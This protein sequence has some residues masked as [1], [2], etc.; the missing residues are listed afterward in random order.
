MRF[1]FHAGQTAVHPP[2]AF[3]NP[4]RERWRKP[5]TDL[6]IPNTGSIICLRNA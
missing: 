2:V 4:R 6:M 1:R 5:I 3:F